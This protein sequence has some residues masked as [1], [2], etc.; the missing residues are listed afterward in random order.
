M[1]A[2]LSAEQHNPGGGL[3]VILLVFVVGMLPHQTL[4]HQ[5]SQEKPK[6]YDL[7]SIVPEHR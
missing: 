2:R 4:C 7:K 5:K 3:A 1:P 6:H